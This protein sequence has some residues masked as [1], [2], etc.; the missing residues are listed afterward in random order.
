MSRR[1]FLSLLVFLGL[2]GFKKP[3]LTAGC[4]VRIKD[5]KHPYRHQIGSPGVVQGPIP[6]PPVMNEWYIPHLQLWRVQVGP[7]CHEDYYAHE[8]EIQ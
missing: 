1:L 8:L 3:V 7:G 2:F 4:R 6:N 5:G